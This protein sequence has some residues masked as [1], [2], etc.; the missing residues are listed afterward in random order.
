MKMK[1][2]EMSRFKVLLTGCVLLLML[3][4]YQS[5]AD[6]FRV[7]YDIQSMTVKTEKISDPRSI[8][9]VELSGI[10]TWE[11]AA[12]MFRVALSII[13]KQNSIRPSHLCFL[14]NYKM[15]VDLCPSLELLD[16]ITCFQKSSATIVKKLI[17]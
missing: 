9:S 2:I 6:N 16:S 5:Y 3:N 14:N 11:A 12:Q 13:I 8:I 15:P 4:C 10:Q 1:F 7:Y 17:L